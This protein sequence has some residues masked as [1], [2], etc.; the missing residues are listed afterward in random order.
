MQMLKETFYTNLLNNLCFSF[1]F[2]A[3]DGLNGR[4]AEE[5][6]LREVGCPMSEEDDVGFNSHISYL[7]SYVPPP[8]FWHL[9]RLPPKE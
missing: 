3:M 1:K 5:R 2:G 7:R 4:K 6:R 8:I 9:P